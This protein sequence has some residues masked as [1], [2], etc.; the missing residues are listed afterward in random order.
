[1]KLNL[2]DIKNIDGSLGVI[3]PKYDIETV[4]EETLKT[5]KWLHFGAG[6]IFRAYMGKVQQVL[7][8]KNLENTGIIVAESFDTEIIDKAYTPFDNLTILTTLNKNGDFQ[9][10]IIGSIVESIKATDENF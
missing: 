8:E 9:N 1:M 7:I 2:K 5:P 10:E 4:K 3:V 6:N